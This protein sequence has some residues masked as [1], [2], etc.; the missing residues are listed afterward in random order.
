MKRAVDKILGEGFVSPDFI[1]SVIE[2]L[3]GYGLSFEKKQEDIYLVTNK[4]GQRA[5]ADF[6]D[7]EAM[8]DSL[9]EIGV[10]FGI[11]ID[12]DKSGKLAMNAQR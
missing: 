9:A 7:V 10:A 1:Q 8:Y 11:T 2:W 4:E 5:I 12:Y 3:S 6:N